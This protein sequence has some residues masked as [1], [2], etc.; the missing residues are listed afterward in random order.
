M[1][2]HIRPFLTL[3]L[4]FWFL[5][6]LLVLSSVPAYAEWVAIGE[7]GSDGTTIYVDPDTI[8]RKGDLVKM[9][10]LFD[11]KTAETYRGSSFLSIK[12][13]DHYDCAEERIRSLAVVHHSGNMGIGRAV[14]I[15]SDEGNWEPVPPQSTGQALWKFACDKP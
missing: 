1:H 10:H 13:Q 12:A 14:Y 4:A 6:T 7:S 15:R 11:Y 2:F 9:W 5:I 3:P 8:R